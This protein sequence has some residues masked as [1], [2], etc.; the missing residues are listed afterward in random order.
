MRSPALPAGSLFMSSALAWTTS[1]VPPPA[2]TELFPVVSVTLGV[3][4]DHLDH[5][6]GRDREIAHVAGVRSL[7]ILQPMLLAVGI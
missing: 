3:D 7:R 6:V 5:A 2:K 4:H 1:A